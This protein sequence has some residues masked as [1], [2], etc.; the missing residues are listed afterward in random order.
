[1]LLVF[2]YQA[3]YYFT[4]SINRIKINIRKKNEDGDDFYKRSPF[5]AILSRSTLLPKQID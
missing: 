5:K 3:V 2:G 4:L 1:M